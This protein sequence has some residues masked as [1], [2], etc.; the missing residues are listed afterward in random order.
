MPEYE[1]VRIEEIDEADVPAGT[2]VVDA[3][4]VN[5]ED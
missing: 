3:E 4:I 2:P 1:D 5:D